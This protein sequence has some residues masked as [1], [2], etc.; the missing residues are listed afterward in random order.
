[1]PKSSS[2]I[3]NEAETEEAFLAAL[4][5]AMQLQADKPDRYAVYVSEGLTVEPSDFAD[6]ANR[7]TYRALRSAYMETGDA[8]CW[9]V[10]RERLIGSEEVIQRRVVD[11]ALNRFST[12]SSIPWLVGKLRKR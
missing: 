5:W 2:P 6:P 8:M 10:L 9:Q 12:V 3:P 1:M 7:E 11:I 4:G